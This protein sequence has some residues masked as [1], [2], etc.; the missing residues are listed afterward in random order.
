MHDIAGFFFTGAGTVPGFLFYASEPGLAVMA[1]LALMLAGCL[2]AMA[3]S[4]APM[5]VA[6]A[7]DD[8]EKR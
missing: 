6:A 7:R 5:R 3:D 8:R 4:Q 2:G 1:M